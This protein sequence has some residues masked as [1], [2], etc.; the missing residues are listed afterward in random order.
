MVVVT[1]TTMMMMVVVVVVIVVVIVV[2]VVVYSYDFH[3]FDILMTLFRLQKESVIIK[4]EA[5]DAYN[6]HPTVTHQ[7][8]SG[9]HSTL[10]R[11]LL[12]ALLRNLHGDSHLLFF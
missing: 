5:Y 2:V 8:S 3:G 6:Y 1:M 12:L 10:I 11:S 4:L 9:Q 7:T